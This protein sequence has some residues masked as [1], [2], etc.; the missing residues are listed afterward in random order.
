MLLVDIVAPRQVHIGIDADRCGAPAGQE[1]RARGIAE[2]RGAIRVRKVHAVAGEPVE[3]RRFRL[4]V[5]LQAADP[6]V[7]IV[8]DEE[9]YVGARVGRARERRREHDSQTDQNGRVT[10]RVKF[11]DL[12]RNAKTRVAVFRRGVVLSETLDMRF[13]HENGVLGGVTTPTLF[14]SIHPANLRSAVLLPDQGHAE[15]GA[16]R[17]H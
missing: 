11:S 1:R 2:R 4:R 9:E 7:E 14:Y 12:L 17:H 5:T 15:F 6:V 16:T 3:V 8:S 10:H 13:L